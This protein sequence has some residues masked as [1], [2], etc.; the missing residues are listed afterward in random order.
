ME[1]ERRRRRRTPSFIYIDT[2]LINVLRTGDNCCRKWR[3]RI[4]KFRVED[5]RTCYNCHW[6]C[7]GSVKVTTWACIA[8]LNLLLCLCAEYWRVSCPPAS[9]IVTWT[10]S[11]VWSVGHPII[12]EIMTTQWGEQPL[13]TCVF[14]KLRILTTSIIQKCGDT[15][16]TMIDLDKWCNQ[17]FFQ[18]LLYSGLWILIKQ[19]MKGS[20]DGILY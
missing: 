19:W 7:P 4:Q 10:M 6:I 20:C 5:P 16:L 17:S 18:V 12:S 2:F 13:R 3:Q 11:H 14:Y 9:V 15:E 8:S 1:K